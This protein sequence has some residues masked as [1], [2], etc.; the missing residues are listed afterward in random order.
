M[1][2]AVCAE[3]IFLDLPITERVQRIAEAGF[4]AEIWDW[5]RHDVEALAATGAMFSS[6]TGY[7]RGDFGAGA[8]ELIRTAQ[9]SIAV[10]QTLNCPRLNL[11][12]TGL[13]GKGLPVVPGR[14]CR[15]RCGFR[16]RA[17]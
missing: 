12:G 4:D 15:V 14:T 17:P 13:D 11:H 8:D 5:T 10:A 6:M 9:E 16:P 3:M 1:R 7:I 2:L